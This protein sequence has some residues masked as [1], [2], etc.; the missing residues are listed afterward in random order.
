MTDGRATLAELQG[1]W[2]LVLEAVIQRV[3]VP[4]PP[5]ELLQV[6]RKFLRD[7]GCTAPDDAARVQ[8]EALYRAY[9]KALH[10]A[11][12]S[13]NPRAG[14]LAEARQWLVHNGVRPDVPAAHAASIALKLS[15]LEVPFQH[16]H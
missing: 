7:Q 13:P 3:K 5:T 9:G 15:E 12:T 2:R 16:K 8:L 10:E 4:K 1:L 14:V 6:A 11:L